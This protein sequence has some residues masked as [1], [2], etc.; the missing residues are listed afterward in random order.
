VQTLGDSDSSSTSDSDSGALLAFK[1]PQLHACWVQAAGC[2][3]C[4]LK[5]LQAR[6]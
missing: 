3:A 6:G 5:V 1:S 2:R 4:E